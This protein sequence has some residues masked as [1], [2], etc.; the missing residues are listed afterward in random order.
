V[1]LVNQDQG[2]LVAQARLALVAAN[3]PLRLFRHGRLLC[4]IGKDDEGRA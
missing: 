3:K 1:I 4:R 2:R